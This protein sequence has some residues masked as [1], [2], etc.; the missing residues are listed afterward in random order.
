MFLLQLGHGGLKLRHLVAGLYPLDLMCIHVWM[1]TVNLL[2]L[3]PRVNICGIR[4]R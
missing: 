3:H 4:S 2:L 1:H